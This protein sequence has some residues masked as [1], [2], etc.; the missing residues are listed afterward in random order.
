VNSRL[1]PAVRPFIAK[2]RIIF[3]S[4]VLILSAMALAQDSS[5]A[6][7]S[8]P[9]WGTTDAPV[10]E[11]AEFQSALA[12]V[13][14]HV[15]YQNAQFGSGGVGL[16]N[17]GTGAIS[18]SG[19]LTPVKAAYIY[20]AVI[21]TGAAPTPD[22]TV[23]LQRLSPTPVSA[24]VS[25]AGTLVGKG[26]SPCWPGNTISVF[27][28][29]VPL[30]VANGNGLYQITLLPGA[31]GTTNGADPWLV[32]PAPLME[33]ASL[34]MVGTGPA[35]QRV[36]IY[37]SGLAGATFHGD[38]GLE[39]SL[40]L[41]AAT[42]GTL[43][44]WNNIGADGQV[45]TSL[46]AKPGNADEITTVNGVHVAGPGSTGIDSDWNGSSAKPLPMLWDD[47]AHDITS[48]APKGT[49]SL[50]IEFYIT[51]STATVDCMTTVANIVEEQ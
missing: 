45:G 47:T 34:V 22:K 39:Y 11:S 24:V 6:T 16:R 41:P 43:T 26:S 46:L 49:T 8:Q 37:D 25:V 20:W 48:A 9:A 10:A 36:A 14:G 42:K 28:G 23:K 19:V 4:V 2:H 3:P 13:S 17:R 50:N 38:T 35:G 44:I 18:V 1:V 32:Y 40:T 15:T 33:G 51:G 21:T 30:A 5:T 7:Q 31:S 12:P 27:R 29:S